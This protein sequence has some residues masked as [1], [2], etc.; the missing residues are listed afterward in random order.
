MKY[1]DADKLIAEIENRL[2]C[3][4]AFDEVGDS[5]WHYDQGVVD[6]YKH[7]KEFITSLKQEQPVEGLEEAAM[8]Y[9]LSDFTNPR[10]YGEDGKP[11]PIAIND[12]FIAGAEWGSSYAVAP[13][14]FK[15]RELKTGRVFLAEWSDIAGEWYER[16]DGKAYQSNEVEII[17][18]DR[19]TPTP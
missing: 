9:Y 13:H 17:P 4:G 16:G 8:S 2:H 7:I 11:Y 1:I 14:Y 6:T 15:L 12:A 5:Q 10:H 18:R 3:N 19:K